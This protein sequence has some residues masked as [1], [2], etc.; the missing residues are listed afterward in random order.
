LTLCAAWV[1]FVFAAFSSVPT[2][3]EQKRYRSLQVQLYDF[4]SL[5]A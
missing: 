5:K 4:G 2:L 1:F 3:H